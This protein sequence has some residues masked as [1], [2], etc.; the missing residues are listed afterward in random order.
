MAFTQQLAHMPARASSESVDTPTCLTKKIA[1]MPS[2]LAGAM[3]DAA[4]RPPRRAAPAAPCGLPAAGPNCREKLFYPGAAHGERVRPR[5]VRQTCQ[6]EPGAP[7]GALAVPLRARQ[8]LGSSCKV[9]PQPRSPVFRGAH[10]RLAPPVGGALTTAAC[11]T[12]RAEAN[13]PDCAL[14]VPLR[15]RLLYPAHFWSAEPHSAQLHSHRFLLFPGGP[16][17][18]QSTIPLNMMSI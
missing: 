2:E 18:V 17:S 9:R 13:A 3:S 8:L 1:S 4:P 16:R 12:F 15:A 14:V 6:A 11:P 10:G 5:C 7:D